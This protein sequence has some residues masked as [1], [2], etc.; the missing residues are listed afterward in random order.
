MVNTKETGWKTLGGCSD[1]P[2]GLMVYAVLAKA[3]DQPAVM[4]G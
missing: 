1:R 2:E 4:G 3:S